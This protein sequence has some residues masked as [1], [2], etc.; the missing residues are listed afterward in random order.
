MDPREALRWAQ[1][2]ILAV[3]RAEGLGWGQ[4]SV[5]RLSRVARGDDTAL[6]PDPAAAPRSAFGSLPTPYHPDRRTTRP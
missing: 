6:P 4:I 1:L 2:L 5:G 3:E